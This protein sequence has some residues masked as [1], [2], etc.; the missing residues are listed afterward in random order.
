MP[1]IQ[2][3]AWTEL[4]DVPLST[5]DDN[6]KSENND[7]SQL[8]LAGKPRWTSTQT[9]HFLETMHLRLGHLNFPMCAKLI[10]VPLPI[11]CPVCVACNLSKAH[12]MS[13]DVQSLR[14]PTRLYEAWA[15][16]Y[17]GP[18]ST[19]T[20]EGHIYWMIL[21]ELMSG[22][23]IIHLLKQQTEFYDIFVNHL[24]TLEAMVGRPRV[25]SWIVHDNATTFTKDKRFLTLLHERGIMQYPSPP[26]AQ[27]AQWSERY[28]RTI[29]AATVA[30]IIYGGAPKFEWGYA[31]RLAV[32]TCINRTPVTHDK[33]LRLPPEQRGWLK[34]EV[35]FGRRLHSLLRSCYPFYCLAFKVIPLAHRSNDFDPIAVPCVYLGYDQT[36]RAYI[37]REIARS[38]VLH[39]SIE[40]VM[41]ERIQ[42][43]R[44]RNQTT[45]DHLIESHRV[46][47]PS[48]DIISEERD[49]VRLL[50]QTVTTYDDQQLPTDVDP[51]TRAIDPENPP[52][53]PAAGMSRRGYNPSE[54]ALNNTLNPPRARNAL[55]FMLNV[56]SDAHK[57]PLEWANRT[58]VTTAL[59][60]SAGVPSQRILT[61]EQIHAL[62]P[63]NIKNAISG[64]LGHLWRERILLSWAGLKDYKVFGPA[65]TADDIPPGFKPIPVRQ[66]YKYKVEEPKA[67]QDILPSECKTREVVQGDQ[68][69]EYRDFDDTFAAVLRPETLRLLL[70]IAVQR[71]QRPVQADYTSAFKHT[72]MDKPVIVRL[73]TG[74]DPDSTEMRDLDAPPLYASLLQGLEG[75]KQGSHLWYTHVAKRLLTHG[76]HPSIQDPCCF[77][78]RNNDSVLGLYVDD[79]ILLPPPG[80][81][82]EYAQW[83][84]GPLALGKDLKVGAC[85]PL[86]NFLRMKYTIDWGPT[87]RRIHIS[88]PI[89]TEALLE[90]AGMLKCNPNQAPGQHKFVWTCQDLASE[91]QIEELKDLGQTSD[92]YRSLIQSMNHITVYTRPDLKYIQSKLAKFM[93]NPG[94]NHWSALKHALRYVKGTET[95]GLMYEWVLNR[96]DV[97]L[98]GW[99]DSSHQDCPDTSKSTLGWLLYYNDNLI[100]YYS[101]L[102]LYVDACINHSEL[103]AA[104]LLLKEIIWIRALLDEIIPTSRPRPP[105]PL[106][107]DNTGA[108]SLFQDGIQHNANKTL[109]KVI[110]HG[111]EIIQNNVASISRTPGP[112]NY[113]DCMTKVKPGTAYPQIRRNLGMSACPLPQTAPL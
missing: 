34:S 23:T 92:N 71:N 86:H 96:V 36:K 57:T 51:G 90:R 3:V 112:A 43:Y 14:V 63:K 111:R 72:A 55:A 74:F 102:G 30:S 9:R 106:F 64:P 2:H 4:L 32:A 109:R 42:P 40:V 67:L 47:T 17:K 33:Q 53:I 101:K 110:H 11:P 59:L 81:G 94:P 45:L 93:R 56:D 82:F 88:Q 91:E 104:L 78:H 61:I 83:L 24:N 5:G 50:Q 49:T 21:V 13:H 22:F 58:A 41:F 39:Y 79:S 108:E 97:G 73:P 18:F 99:S 60:L 29:Y 15:F 1:S 52:Y 65:F 113:A 48:R 46:N 87:R 75:I 100:S 95:E 77:L 105:V 27:W 85:K 54:T 31:C 19:P 26:Y 69:T 25:V 16:D 44:N 20:P 7:H 76:Y 8:T 38:A 12:N 98:V 103:H 80:A 62:T 107:V 28:N 84:F 89:H 37:L 10:D 35:Y 70:A 6:L 66:I 68:M